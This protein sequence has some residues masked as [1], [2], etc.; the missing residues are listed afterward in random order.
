MRRVLVGVVALALAI[1][2]SAC[3]KPTAGSSAGGASSAPPRTTDS[4]PRSSAV[5]PPDDAKG[6]ADV[7]FRG[8]RGRESV[9]CDSLDAEFA[10]VAR[11]GKARWS[12]RP[13]R[14]AGLVNNLDAQGVRIEPASGV[15]AEG[16]STTV[17]VRGSFDKRIQ[18]YF[19]VLV[20]S[21]DGSTGHAIEFKCR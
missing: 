6:E 18:P 11:D 1:G 7:T 9:S 15:L 16:Q 17:R 20:V 19:Y 4:G 10:V 14:D 8:T 13:K 21:R 12:A 3:Q 5:N 2:A